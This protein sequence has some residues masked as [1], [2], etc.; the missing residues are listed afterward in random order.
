VDGVQAI[1][2]SVDPPIVPNETEAGRDPV[3]EADEISF[4]GGS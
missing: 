1:A 4:G 3:L 2:I